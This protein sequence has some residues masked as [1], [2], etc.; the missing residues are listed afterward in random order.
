MGTKEKAAKKKKSKRKHK[1]INQTWGREKE[2][3]EWREGG[4][5]HR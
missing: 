4:K 2:N 1:R 5:G 3:K